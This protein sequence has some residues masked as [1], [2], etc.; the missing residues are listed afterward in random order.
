MAETEVNEQKAKKEHQKTKQIPEKHWPSKKTMN[1][2]IKK[3]T[4]AHPT[5]LIPI[6]VAIS[7]VAA[8]FGKFAVA[9]RIAKVEEE[10]AQ[11]NEQKKLLAALKG[12]IADY[13][14]VKKEYDRYSY[15]GFDRTLQN[16]L[17][18]LTLMEE[19]LFPACTVEQMAVAGRQLTLT[20]SNLSLKDNAE[21][22]DRLEKHSDIV[23]EVYVSS[24]SYNDDKK[25]GEASPETGDRQIVQISILLRNAE[26][27][28]GEN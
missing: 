13:N 23:E 25:E 6:L 11:L 24:T 8:L 12:T 22:V 15:Q 5:R 16:R 27:K 14:D 26:E 3:K 17:D 20:I 2:Y 10:Y 28:G 4:I 21:L 1:L 9:D 18:I 19:E 7:I